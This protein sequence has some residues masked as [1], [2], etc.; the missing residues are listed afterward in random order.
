VA[1]ELRNHVAREVR[2]KS[3]IVARGDKRIG[4]GRI[5]SNLG[6]YGKD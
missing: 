4:R 1:F 2:R 5:L 6:M 3:Q